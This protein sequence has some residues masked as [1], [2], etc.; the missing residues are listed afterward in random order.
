MRKQGIIDHWILPENGLNKQTKYE[1]QPIGNSPEIMPHD[2][3]LNKDLHKGVN[4][5]CVLTNGMDNK[6]PKKFPKTT[7]KRMLS[8]Y[9]RT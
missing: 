8:S 9:A 7:T 5:L 6:N 4:W 1:N 2:S 3:N